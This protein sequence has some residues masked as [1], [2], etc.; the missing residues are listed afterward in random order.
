MKGRDAYRLCEVA[1]DWLSQNGPIS[2]IALADDMGIGHGSTYDGG[3]GRLRVL[4]GVSELLG[5]P[6]EDFRRGEA[7]TPYF[8]LFHEIAGHCMQ[9]EDELMRKRTLSKVLF[10]SRYAGNGSPRYYGVDDAGTPHEMYFSRPDEIA[11]QYMCIKCGHQFLSSLFNEEHL[12]LADAMTLDYV[13][14]RMSCSC[15][16]LPSNFKYSSVGDVLNGLNDVF[17]KTVEKPRPFEPSN[18]DSD[19]L[20][21][22]NDNWKNFDAIAAVKSCDNGLRQDAMMV[23]AFANTMRSMA[24]CDIETMVSRE[25]YKVIDLGLNNTFRKKGCPIWPPPNRLSLNLKKLL[26]VTD[27]IEKSEMPDL[28]GIHVDL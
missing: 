18:D 2:D 4:V 10:L 26:P 13:N 19:A 1:R 15:S 27:G 6:D 7:L 17:R 11:A 8:A 5:H 16:F 9:V 24:K 22:L 21:W 25:V 28:S 20:S 23:C 12:G 14:Y 3:P